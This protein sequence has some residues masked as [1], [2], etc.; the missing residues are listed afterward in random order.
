MRTAL[1]I[2][3]GVHSVRLAIDQ[4]YRRACVENQSLKYPWLF[5]GKVLGSLEKADNVFNEPVVATV[6]G[7]L[8]F[9]VEQLSLQILISVSVCLLYRYS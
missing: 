1:S 7:L 3:L 9:Q 8:I 6:F 2:K 5:L 4:P